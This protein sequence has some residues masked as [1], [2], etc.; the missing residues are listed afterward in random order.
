MIKT[1]LI[2]I[3][4]II[5]FINVIFCSL[6]G[7]CVRQL[8]EQNAPE[9]DV[10]KAVTELK[11]AKKILENKVCH[12]KQF[13]EHKYWFLILIKDCLLVHNYIEVLNL[14]LW[15]NLYSNGFV[16]FTN[17]YRAF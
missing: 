15:L 17:I 4:F 1:W 12:S 16:Y 7:D 11:A 9:N 2:F 10:K 5:D 3:D 13:N 14:H 6:Q 8:K